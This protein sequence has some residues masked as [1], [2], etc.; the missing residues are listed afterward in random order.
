MKALNIRTNSISYEGCKWLK[1]ANWPELKELN[2]KKNS[3]GRGC[4][5]LA[6]AR[7]SLEVV[8]LGGCLID[9]RSC[10]AIN[11]ANWPSLIFLGLEDNIISNAGAKWLSK[12]NWKDLKFLLLCKNDNITKKGFDYLSK[13]NANLLY[14]LSITNASYFPHKV[15]KL[16][17]GEFP[18]LC[19][20]HAVFINNIH[21][22]RRDQ[23]DRYD[24]EK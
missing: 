17:K 4:E 3:I 13:I 21:G 18:F 10:K 9:D 16:L 2:L 12:G 19:K 11:H 15:Y 23:E 6:T 7:W 24:V 5:Y 20:M 14:K 22:R 1:E 8:Q